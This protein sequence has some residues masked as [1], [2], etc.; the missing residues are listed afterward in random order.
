M[1]GNTAIYISFVLA[2]IVTAGL[3]IA[4]WNSLFDTETKAGHNRAKAW[5]NHLF[6]GGIFMALVG[7]LV[8]YILEKYGF[9]PAIIHGIGLGMILGP[10]MRGSSLSFSEGVFTS[11]TFFGSI[12]VFVIVVVFG[13][14]FAIN[15]MGIQR[16][17]TFDF[18]KNKIHTLSDQTI[19]ALKGLD[20]KIEVVGFALDRQLHIE[21]AVRAVLK[22]YRAINRD[23]FSFRIINPMKAPQLA[24]CY[25]ARLRADDK[26]RRIIPLF[27]ARGS[28]VESKGG[29]KFKG[30]KILVE[31]LSEQELTNKLIKVSRKK[32]KEVCFLSGRSQPSIENKN[33]PYDYGKFKQLLIERGLKVRSID[34]VSLEN[35]PASCS[36]V[37]NVSPESRVL[38]QQRI[39]LTTARLSNIEVEAI[40]RYLKKGGKMMVF[41]E[42]LIET[43]LEKTLDTYGIQTDSRLVLDF[44]SGFQQNPL[45]P[46]VREFNKSHAITKGF[47]GRTRAVLSWATPVQVKTGRPKGVVLT[48]LMTTRSL[49]L[50]TP[51]GTKTC[52]VFSIKNPNTPGFRRIFRFMRA[53]KYRTLLSKI[54]GGLIEQQIKDAK[55]GPF[56][57]A[58]AASKKEKG[59]KE[60]TRI[61]VFGDSMTASNN[62]LQF[63]RP[64]VL[65]SI[66]WLTQEKSLVHI[67][68]KRRK[69]SR[70]FLTSA[71]KNFI[72]YTSQYGI[73][74]FFLFVI[75]LVMSVRRHQ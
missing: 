57:L 51:T 55:R 23:K 34:L 2:A 54:A 36:I 21:G 53:V 70:I 38:M 13:A 31:G 37:V 40:Q 7:V 64:L 43:N 56:N 29:L 25:G 27:L 5:G 48:N 41:Q 24:Q 60:E 72:N 28:C 8:Y 69:P 4:I 20:E 35:V 58:V 3:L 50:R 16:S 9:A 26:K 62:L 18:N 66:Y 67:P 59:Q 11:S 30:K 46:D 42:P 52:C 73:P 12:T 39:S 74:A 6:I 14:L 61:V 32:Q 75:F 65:N 49:R 10:M 68:S 17:K 19:K 15:Y 71:Q 22:K 47:Y 45:L 63:N 33:K 44:T 1:K